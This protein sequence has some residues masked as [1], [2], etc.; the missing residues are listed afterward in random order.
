MRSYGYN[1]FPEI[2]NESYDSEPNLKLRTKMIIDNIENV[3]KLPYEQ[4][5]EIYYDTSFQ[6]KLIHN[7]QLFLKQRGS[8][9]W[10]EAIRWLTEN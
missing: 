3:C 9:K 6:N 4:L 2:F 5:N 7:R 1:T 10:E 8:K